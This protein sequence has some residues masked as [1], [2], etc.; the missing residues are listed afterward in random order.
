MKIKPLALA[1][2]SA[3]ALS[4]CASVAMA[5]TKRMDVAS[6]FGTNMFLGQ[7]AVHLADE[8][9]TITDGAINMR[10]YEP[11]DLVPP[12]EVFNA[13]STGAVDAGWD[14]IGY[15]AGTVPLVN[16]YGSLPFGPSAEVMASWMWSGDG[17]KY[18]QQAYDPY[19][20][21]VLACFISPQETGGFYNKPIN[22]IGDFDGLRMRISGL[23]ARVLNQF[24]ASTQLI[25][26]G[27]IYLALE[28]GRIDAAEFSVPSV[29]E[30]TGL[31][32]ITQYYYF[33]GW[34]QS[35]S[36]FSLMMN[37]NVWNGLT[38]TQQAQVETACRSTLQ[39]SMAQAVPDQ[40]N[41]LNRMQAATGI[42]VR[43]FSDDVL[44][45]LESG[46]QKVLAEEFEN[47][48]G[49]REAYESL[50]EHKAMFDQWYELQEMN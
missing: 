7:G 45:E 19:N 29:D 42:E 30:S 18:L 35:T 9:R 13:V 3:A 11:G 49:F 10:V 20:V 38:A 28:R 50:M 5:Q 34:H 32:E 1:F 4:V 47:T 36:W 33:P 41:A 21:K 6:V 2:A 43:R 22:T 25:P 44:Q 27:E 14:W 31:Q 24:G 12:F 17:A 46:W 40:I 26:G 16:M 23:G 39:W 48:P 8:L 37:K 15:W